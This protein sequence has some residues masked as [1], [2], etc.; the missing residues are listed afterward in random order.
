MWRTRSASS[1]VRQ[2][3][4]SCSAAQVLKCALAVIHCRG[5]C[6]AIAGCIILGFTRDGNHVISYTTGG[7]AAGLGQPGL[8]LQLWAFCAGRRLRRAWSVPL[9]RTGGY[10]AGLGQ[11]PTD[12]E[13]ETDMS[14]TVAEA[15]DGSLIGAGVGGQPVGAC[16]APSSSG[17]S[18]CRTDGW[19]VVGSVVC[20][21]PQAGG[22]RGR[23]WLNLQPVATHGMH[24]HALPSS[25]RWPPP[26]LSSRPPL[27]LP[28]CS[29]C[30]SG[31]W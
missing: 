12:F 13:T 17:A 11:E 26:A 10:L 18:S 8:C 25:P 5:C 27:P 19:A 22:W 9:F 16:M 31:T 2:P 23:C 6:A 3:G 15:P 24:A 14:L 29:L 21:R 30:C 20:G 1:V 7:V 4:A 28:P